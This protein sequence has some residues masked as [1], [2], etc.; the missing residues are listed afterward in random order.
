[1]YNKQVP[2]HRIANLLVRAGVAFAF[3]YPPY[4]ALSDPT[5]WLGYFPPFMLAQAA[6]WGVPALALLHA[7]GALEVVI[8]LWI[9]SGWRIFIPSLVAA[10]LLV[11]II[12]FG[13]ND[14]EVLFRDAAIAAAALSLAVVNWPTKRDSTILGI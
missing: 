10:A 5:S 3:A 13:Y 9:L 11:A 7:F 8:A 12:A 1:M 2:R 4:A 6:Q 14:F